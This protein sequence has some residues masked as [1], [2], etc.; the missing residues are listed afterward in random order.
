MRGWQKIKT[1]IW[2]LPERLQGCITKPTA[3]DIEGAN[4]STQH[5]TESLAK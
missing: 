1:D 5:W 2:I 3:A 4:I